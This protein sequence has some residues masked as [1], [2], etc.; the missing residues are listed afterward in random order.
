MRGR[1]ITFEGVDGAGKSSHL[2]PFVARVREAGH[3]VVLSRE[4]GGT[5]LAESLREILLA[6]AMPELT[7]LLLMFAAR[8]DHLHA[9]IEPALARGAWVVCDRFTDST[10][11]YQGSGRGMDI[12][13]IEL[14]AARVHG[15]HNPDRTYLFDLDA[16]SAQARRAQARTAD[17]FEQEALDFFDRVRAGYHAIARREPQRFCVVD[18]AQSFDQVEANVV[19]DFQHWYQSLP[20]AGR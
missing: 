7:E 15:H 17:R 18:A 6:Q 16:A 12:T 19:A 1:F 4:P 8:A 13:F 11:A 14:L 9:V 3:E 2:A 20:E 10:L 5:A